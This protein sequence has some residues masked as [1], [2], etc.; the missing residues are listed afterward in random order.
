M[1][2]SGRKKDSG[3]A[4]NVDDLDLLCHW[5]ALGIDPDTRRRYGKKNS[6]IE[7]NQKLWCTQVSFHLSKTFGALMDAE[8][9]DFTC[10]LLAGNPGVPGELCVPALDPRG[11][12]LLVLLL[13][14]AGWYVLRRRG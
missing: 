5:S 11:V 4:G 2:R 14:G 3:V 9:T 1:P 10:G 8:E 12:V 13:S 6:V 7:E